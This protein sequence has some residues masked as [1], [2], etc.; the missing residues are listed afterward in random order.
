MR[1]SFLSTNELTDNAIAPAS[2]M[3]D[4]L[5]DFIILFCFA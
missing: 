2:M 4:A 5:M 1:T 3:I